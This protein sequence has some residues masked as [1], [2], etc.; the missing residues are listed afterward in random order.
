MGDPAVD[1][2]TDPLAI[3]GFEDLLVPDQPGSSS[4]SSQEEPASNEQWTALNQDAPGQASGCNLAVSVE[5]AAEVLGLSVNAI[6]KRLRKG[7]LSGRKVPGKFKDQW[8]VIL[9]ENQIPLQI[10]IEN[11]PGVSSGCSQEEPASNKQWTTSNQDAP[12]QAL[13][14]NSS[15]QTGQLMLIREMMAK[16]EQLQH[17]NGYLKA[18]LE[19]EQEHVKLLTDR[20]HKRGPW[21]RFWDWFTGQRS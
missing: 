14:S 3:E 11:E 6:H 4:G 2:A 16:I 17:D 12:G 13:G 7:T 18:Q 15:Q 10:E 19:A 20:Q 9:Q 1:K 5:K 21:S 8:L